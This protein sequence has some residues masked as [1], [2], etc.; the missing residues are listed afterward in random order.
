MPTLP[1]FVLLCVLVLAAAVLYSSGGHAGATAYLAAMVLVGVAPEVMKPTALVMNILVAMIGTARWTNN[2]KVPWK[3]VRWLVLGSIP[4]AFIGGHV[5]LTT[6]VYLPLLGILLLVGAVRLWMSEKPGTQHELPHWGWLLA[7]GTGL[8]FLAG[9]TGI[10]G[11]IFLTP[12]LILKNWV[13]PKKAAGAAI[14]FILVNSIAGLLGHLSG[15]RSIPPQAAILAALA[16]GGG[17]VGTY[18]G[19]HRYKGQMLRRVNA[20]VLVISSAKL[21]FEAL[22]G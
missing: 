22:H 17:L 1:L 6:R 10:G 2:L 3:A 9:L 12:I 18:L 5:Q 13:G 21:L 16:V 4:A 20:V 11:G 14:V 15:V 19:V 8:G 7:T